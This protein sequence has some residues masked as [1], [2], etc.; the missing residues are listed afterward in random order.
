MI[1]PYETKDR[2]SLVAL[3]QLNIPEFFDASEVEDFVVYLEQ[4]AQN[5]FVLEEAGRIIGSGGYNW[6][7]GGATARISWDIIHPDFQG[8][9]LGKTLT[10]FR[11]NEIKKNPVVRL[12][13]V[14][15]S[16]LVFLFYQKLGFKLEKIEKDFWAKGFD[17]YQ[18][19]LEIP[20]PA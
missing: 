9:G 18:L 20:E 15:T 16:Q 1:R 8:K 13:V 17:L 3:L 10:I 7:D 14:R 4:D 6:F 5:Y 11:I 19:R 2:E 12:V